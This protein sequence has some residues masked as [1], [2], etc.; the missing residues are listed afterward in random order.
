MIEFEFDHDKSLSNLNKHGIDFEQ[1]QALW[2]DFNLLE[3]QARSDDEPRFVVIGK[4][5]DKHWSAVITYRDGRIRI[6][7]VRRSRQAE[8]KLYES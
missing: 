5:Q 2:S 6:I 8:V 1:A 3:V 4:I 7:S